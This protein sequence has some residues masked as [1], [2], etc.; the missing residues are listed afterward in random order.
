MKVNVLVFLATMAVAKQPFCT[1]LWDF[2][3]PEEGALIHT[4]KILAIAGAQNKKC[5]ISKEN[6]T[7]LRRDIGFLL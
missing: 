4:G 5:Q 7:A 1:L 6:F 2:L 3:Q